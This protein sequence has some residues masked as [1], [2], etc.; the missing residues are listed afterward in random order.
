MTKIRSSKS[1]AYADPGHDNG[2]KQTADARLSV[3]S[4]LHLSPRKQPQQ[5]RA[6]DTW[7][8]ILEAAAAVFAEQGYSGTTTNK[9]AIRAGVSIGSLYQYFPN[10][11]AILAGLRKRHLS[12]VQSVVERSM[13]KMRDV[14]VPIHDALGSLLRGLIDLHREN[15][16]LARAL[17]DEVVPPHLADAVH[18]KKEADVYAREVEK[19]LSRRSDIRSGNL[20]AMAHILVQTT[21]ALTRWFVHEAPEDLD[22]KVF[23]EEALHLLT[24]YVQQP[25]NI[26]MTF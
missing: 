25:Y 19:I 4:S 7:A 21:Q 1:A 12:D 15:P 11:D 26:I 20:T 13:L 16:K 9:I 14:S 17:S 5:K 10:K 24:S 18:Q 2:S 23:V 6:K 3:G 22:K 8:A